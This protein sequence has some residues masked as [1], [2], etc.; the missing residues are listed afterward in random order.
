MV[1]SEDLFSKILLEPARNGADEL[2]IVSGYATAAM[3]DRHI[4]SI[5][6]IKPDIKIN[7]IVGMCPV[8][9]ISLTNHE[10]FKHL[11]SNNFCCSY[12]CNKPAVHS[13][14]YVWTQAAK[15]LFGFVG[16]ANYTQMAFS[17]KQ[18]EAMTH[19]DATKAFEYFQNLV[20]DAIYCTHND[21]ENL[22]SIYS[23]RKEQN[24]A[25]INQNKTNGPIPKHLNGLPYQVV[26]LLTRGGTTGK[27][28]G[29]NWGQRPGRNGNQAYIALRSKIYNLE[30]FPERPIQFT[31]LTDDNKTL[32]CSRV[33]DYSKA[34][35]TPHNNSLLGEY[36]RNRLG[37]ASGQFVE[38]I[39]L[40]QHGR[41]D[42]T[43]YKI[44]D[45]TYFM[46]FSV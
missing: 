18:R 40:E 19:C 9:G 17:P 14:I 45:E 7:L 37:L 30:F 24:L 13:K 6:A 46:D 21:T 36:F 10:R 25:L 44:D 33:Q 42:V 1:L 41:T 39:H 12:L 4:N 28:S 3:A 31:V 22:I 38:K 16:S 11:E 34:I 20:S 8:D 35:S 15:P 5:K 29:L 26:S 27:L 32:I 43:F 23:E 2:C